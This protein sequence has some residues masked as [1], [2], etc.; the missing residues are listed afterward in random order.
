MSLEN[1]IAQLVQSNDEVTQR[2]NDVIDVVNEKMG[3][4]DSRM[5]QKE[6]DVDDL[7]SD[8]NR[9]LNGKYVLTHRSGHGQLFTMFQSDFFYQQNNPDAIR[10]VGYALW[11]TP[12]Y[13]AG[14]R[15]DNIG[16]IGSAQVFRSGLNNYSAFNI[17]CRAIF[18]QEILGMRQDNS[19]PLE[20][21]GY[22]ISFDDVLIDGKQTRI[23]KTQMSG[24][25]HFMFD[26]SFQNG[27]GAYRDNGSPTLRH[28]NMGS[29]VLYDPVND[30]YSF[31]DQSGSSDMMRS[32]FN[33]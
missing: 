32:M 22:G 31:A 21:A 6:N 2:A 16:F 1:D 20:E 4:I 10:A 12:D 19:S 30:A 9:I 23:I 17:F 28:E 8:N 14:H 15:Y 11:L 18:D 24:G 13:N 27:G 5:A 29:I 7:I 25:G 33:L 26:G 3:E